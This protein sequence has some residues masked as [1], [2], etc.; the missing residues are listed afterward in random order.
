MV[1]KQW[2][3]LLSLLWW[4]D[5]FIIRFSTTENTL[6]DET[7]EPVIDV[8]VRREFKLVVR[9]VRIPLRFRFRG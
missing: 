3:V 9:S 1:K 4:M 2:K 5:E 7:N 6:Q 8:K